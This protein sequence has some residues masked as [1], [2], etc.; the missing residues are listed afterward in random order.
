MSDD[1]VPLT[2]PLPRFAADSCETTALYRDLRKP[3]LRYLVCLGLSNDEAQDVVQDA[4]LSLQR[5][6]AAGG[7]QENIR[8]WLFRVAHNHARTRQNNLGSQT[9]EGVVVN[10][11][12]RRAPFPLAKSGMINPSALLPRSGLRPISRPWSTANGRSAHEGTDVS[13]DQHRGA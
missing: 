11:C 7:P 4:F 1:S 10:G 2:L 8:S 12:G 3:L 5:H 9:I 6:L 13:A